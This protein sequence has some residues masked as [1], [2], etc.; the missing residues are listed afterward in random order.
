MTCKGKSKIFPYPHPLHPVNFSGS[1]SPREGSGFWGG[2][3]LVK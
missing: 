1:L 3:D 2:G